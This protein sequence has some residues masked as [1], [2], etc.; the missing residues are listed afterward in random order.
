MVEIDRLE[1]LLTAKNEIGRSLGNVQK[2]LA[3]I[4]KQTQKTS[5]TFSRL[6]TVI[7]GIGAAFA[8][9]KDLQVLGRLG[10]TILQAGQRAE[11]S[12]LQLASLINATTQ[13]SDATGNALSPMGNLNASLAQATKLYEELKR[14]AASSPG[15]IAQD[16]IDISSFAIPSLTES[17]ITD[18]VQQ[19]ELLGT[20]FASLKSQG[21]ADTIMEARNELQT[22]FAGDVTNAA[23]QFG[24]F[25][26]E[27]NGGTTAFKA[28]F[29][30]AKQS[31]TAFEFLSKSLEGI[32]IGQQLAADSIDNNFSVIQSGIN[33]AFEQISSQFT[34][35]FKELQQQ[36]VGVFFQDGPNGAK[37]F[38]AELQ[39]I[40][41]ELGTNLSATMQAIAP[42]IK[43]TFDAVVAAVGLGVEAVRGLSQVFV[44]NG[45]VVSKAIQITGQLV[46]LIG[47]SFLDVLGQ[48]LNSVRGFGVAVLDTWNSLGFGTQQVFEGIGQSILTAVSKSLTLALNLVRQFVK[49]FLNLLSPLTL[50]LT[51]RFAKSFDKSIGDTI[52]SIQKRFKS[53]GQGIQK[54]LSSSV[55]LGASRLTIPVQPTVDLSQLTATSRT[56]G[57]DGGG[58]K[59]A[60]GGRRGGRSIASQ[61]VNASTVGETQMRASKEQ[62]E[63]LRAQ[64][65]L[66]KQLN[67]IS[68]IFGAKE[69]ANAS[70]LADLK[71]ES[72][73]LEVEKQNI[74]Q[75][76]LGFSEAEKQARLEG[77]SAALKTNEVKQRELEFAQKRAVIERQITENGE[78]RKAD[79]A[80]LIEGSV[81]YDEQLALINEKYAGQNMALTK[82]IELLGIA[83]DQ[84]AALTSV[85]GT[86]QQPI[87]QASA[88]SEGAADN[89][90]GNFEQ[91]ASGIGNALSGAFENGEFSARKFGEAALDVV[92]NL[93]NS[94]AESALSGLLGGSGGGGGFLSSLF[95]GGGG[96]GFLSSL[97]GGFRASGGPVSPNKSYVVGERGPELFMPSAAGRIIPNGGG[98]NLAGG[99]GGNVPNI[100]VIVNA[101]VEDEDGAARRLIT[102][103]TARTLIEGYSRSVVQKDANRV[104]NRSTFEQRRGG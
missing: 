53:A 87:Q 50:G 35:A 42:L 7:V 43:P 83:Q 89:M 3:G 32:A 25:V 48:A 10:G 82:Q 77:I 58:N 96:G 37:V 14:V 15:V 41:T 28:N 95:G 94:V 46:A 26:A 78:K 12:R 16:L 102:N 81:S 56:G 68:E 30:A 22:F 39:K 70:Q 69:I 1:V 36:L 47:G 40:T 55:N 13:F 100:T 19:A 45:S 90:L 27:I 80:A 17:G 88:S 51:G 4:E 98:G 99:G 2:Q 93:V 49:S 67:A 24:R 64:L 84:G 5:R 44:E 72:K 9:V 11:K 54:A 23:S 76:A 74:Q 20:V 104:F 52:G 60:S 92:F 73:Q 101:T 29:E 57:G 71:V 6:G 86:M 38:N 79:I 63:S 103:S 66:Q 34:P 65:E 61:G 8:A 33:Q 18:A 91:A 75:N 97:F 62:E 85:L 59:T 21:L 31:G